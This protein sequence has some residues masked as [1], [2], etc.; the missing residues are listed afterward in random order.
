MRSIV[1]PI[2]FA[3]ALALGVVASLAVACSGS[4]RPSEDE[5]G[6][7]ASLGGS[8]SGGGDPTPAA[9]G[10]GG[11]AGGTTLAAGG[12]TTSSTVP[13]GACQKTRLTQFTDNNDQLGCGYHRAVAT[14]PKLVRD[15]MYIA[16]AEPFY[17]SSYH[18]SPGESCG[19]CWELTTGKTTT[20]VIVADLCPIEGNPPCADPNQLHFDLVTNAAT[21]VGGGT[22]DMAVARP[23]ACPMSGNIGIEVTDRSWSYFQAAFFGYRVPLRLVEFQPVGGA[24]WKAMTRRWGAVWDNMDNQDEAFSSTSAGA[25]SNGVGVTLRLTSAQGQ[26]LTSQVVLSN[27]NSAKGA[28]LDLGAQF[29]N[30]LPVSGGACSL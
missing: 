6:M 1:M 14:I 25:G 9:G 2:R 3:E 4:S 12:A 22:M 16:M 26:V 15:R 10:H 7:P 11:N 5:A 13:T 19:E 17:G 21:T 28:A 8:S 24:T 23:V 27:A 20:I 18:G 29:D 30:L